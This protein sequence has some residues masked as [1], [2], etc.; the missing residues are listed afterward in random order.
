MPRSKSVKS[1][2]AQVSGE[3]A[4]PEM[5][6]NDAIRAVA[7]ECPNHAARVYANAAMEAAT[8]YGSEGLRVQVLYMLANVRHWRGPRA[9]EVK[10][11]L[12]AYTKGGKHG[13]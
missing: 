11:V 1:S 10:A 8:M 2:A 6:V 9:R 5:S 7:V 4:K 13:R 3:E 12:K